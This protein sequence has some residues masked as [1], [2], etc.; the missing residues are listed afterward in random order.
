VEVAAGSRIPAGPRD[1]ESSSSRGRGALQGQWAGRTRS[2]CIPADPRRMREPRSPRGPRGPR[3]R[4][5]RRASAIRTCGEG[6]PYR[7]AGPWWGRVPSWPCR[8]LVGWLPRGQAGGRIDEPVAGLVRVQVG[9]C[10]ARQSGRRPRAGGD[11]ARRSGDESLAVIH[12]TS[13]RRPGVPLRARRLLDEGQHSAETAEVNAAGARR[14]RWAAASLPT[15]GG[16]SRFTRSSRG[17]GIPRGP[18]RTVL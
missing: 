6:S 8:W 18:P 12:S 3:H 9:R 1:E 2:C 15:Q 16:H 11:P 17:A 10:A 13:P 7:Q 14:K 5:E 4:G